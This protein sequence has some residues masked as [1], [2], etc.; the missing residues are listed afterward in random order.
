M[1]IY[2]DKLAHVQVIFNSPYSVE[3]M[4]TREDTLGHNLVA[5]Y[6]LTSWAITRSQQYFCFFSLAT[7]SR[8]HCFFC[9]AWQPIPVHTVPENEDNLLSSHADCPRQVKNKFRNL[10][11][12][13]GFRDFKGF[14]WF[15]STSPWNF[16][17]KQKPSLMDRNVSLSTRFMSP[18]SP[19]LHTEVTVR[20]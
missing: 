1:S 16:N 7:H 9:L 17:T 6:I 15:Q 14:G 20:T 19:V 5:P 4:C 12:F 8:S 18:V 13:Q 10:S 11:N 3:Q 2:S